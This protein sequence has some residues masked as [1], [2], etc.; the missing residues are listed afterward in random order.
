LIDDLFR[1]EDET[2][3]V[4][5]VH[6][7]P[8]AGRSEVVGRH[9]DALKIRVAA[10]P[11]NG[12][13]NVEISKLL[14]NRFGVAPS[15]VELTSGASNRNKAVKVVGVDEAIVRAVLERLVG[16]GG[17]ARGASARTHR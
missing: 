7:Q 17:D 10:P 8:G 12:R 14:A 16:Q 9:G 11:E 15:A 2:T 6:A 13:A 5:S 1:M 4:L 3:A